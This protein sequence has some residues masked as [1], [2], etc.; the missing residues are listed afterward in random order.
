MGCWHAGTS[1]AGPLRAR[2]WRLVTSPDASR[3]AHIPRAAAAPGAQETVSVVLEPGDGVPLTTLAGE[4][5]AFSADEAVVVLQRGADTAAAGEPARPRVA[6]VDRTGTM[7]FDEAG[8]VGTV[9]GRPGSSD[10][11]V[12]V[13][14]GG[15]SHGAP[16]GTLWLLAPGRAPTLLLQQPTL[17]GSNGGLLIT[18]DQ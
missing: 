18:G 10:L 12:G 4:A 3:V 6:V 13:V 15:T 8:T 1:P 7:L 14:H 9:L 17:D 11:A 16:E 2:P 5:V